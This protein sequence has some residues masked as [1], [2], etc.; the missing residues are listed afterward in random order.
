MR[1]PRQWFEDPLSTVLLRPCIT[2]P[3]D[4][5]MHTSRQLYSHTNA[6]P[7]TAAAGRS[8]MR[9]RRPQ[10]DLPQMLQTILR[11]TDRSISSSDIKPSAKILS[12]S[13][14][15]GNIFKMPSSPNHPSSYDPNRL[16][17]YRQG[18]RRALSHPGASRIQVTAHIPCTLRF[19]LS[20]RIVCLQL[21]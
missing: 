19:V 14:L 7:H 11:H 3:T 4:L 16:A 13:T 6:E 9:Q 2:V 17:D 5:G 20:L 1:Q 8:G 21:S 15:D 12:I 10:P 18:T